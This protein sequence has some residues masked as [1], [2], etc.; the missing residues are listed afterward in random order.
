[1]DP[2]QA[3]PRQGSIGAALGNTAQGEEPARDLTSLPT[4]VGLET[5]RFFQRTGE[6]ASE[7]V[8]RPLSAIGKMIEGIGGA[9]DEETSGPAGAL[10]RNP[11][12]QTR[13]RAPRPV[14]RS[15]PPEQTAHQQQSQSQPSQRYRPPQDGFA[16]P[17]SSPMGGLFGRRPVQ[18]RPVTP[19]S[20]LESRA[21]AEAMARSRM[22]F[23][24]PPPG[25]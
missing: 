9:E 12:Y 1:M 19:T 3:P 22:D 17:E 14:Y 23:D 7:A 10:P 16:T 11:S 4:N 15:P 6:I 8:S 18:D 25:P 21:V 24:T 2:R 13:I 5:R 20:R